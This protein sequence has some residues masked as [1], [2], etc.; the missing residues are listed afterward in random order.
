METETLPILNSATFGAP[1]LRKGFFEDGIDMV[2]QVDKLLEKLFSFFFLSQ[3]I[4]IR[5]VSMNAEKMNARKFVI[6]P[7][8]LIF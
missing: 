6:R 1:N 2:S 5:G 3:E 7:Y 4:T 8:C